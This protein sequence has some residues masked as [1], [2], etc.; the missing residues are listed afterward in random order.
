MIE[1]VNIK[2]CYPHFG[3]CNGDVRIDRM[4]KW[5]NPFHMMYASKL[6]RELVI[7]RYITWFVDQEMVGALDIRELAS[8]RR[9]GCW[10]K[11]LEC[12]GDYLKKRLDELQ[13]NKQSVLL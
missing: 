9:L 13:R 7:R 11:P 12:H 5:G 6:E 3:G 10:C 8:A 4:T 2:T 1:V